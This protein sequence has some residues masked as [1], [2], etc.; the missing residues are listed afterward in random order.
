[1]KYIKC[2]FVIL[3]SLILGFLWQILS[4]DCR[5]FRLFER[6]YWDPLR[7]N[8]GLRDRVSWVI[9]VICDTKVKLVQFH[10]GLNWLWNNVIT[11]IFGVFLEFPSYRI[12][13]S[14]QILSLPI[15]FLFLFEHLF[16]SFVVMMSARILLSALAFLGTFVLIVKLISLR[17]LDWHVR[18]KGRIIMIWVLDRYFALLWKLRPSFGKAWVKTLS[19]KGLVRNWILNISFLREVDQILIL[20]SMG[21]FSVK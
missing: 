4:A 15:V 2:I 20:I 10:S 13:N 17:W 6:P 1:M 18:R 9:V 11:F 12:H 3:F 21:S 8:C 5:W 7:R 14:D 19:L 16:R